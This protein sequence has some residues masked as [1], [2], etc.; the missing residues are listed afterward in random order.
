VRERKVHAIL[1]E[2]V[3]LSPTWIVPGNLAVSSCD[4][5]LLQGRQIPTCRA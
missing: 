3:Y 1:L 4:H 5:E 2:G